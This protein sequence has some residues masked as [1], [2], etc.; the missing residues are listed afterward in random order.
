MPS[1]TDLYIQLF[2]KNHIQD[3]DVIEMSEHGRVGNVSTGTGFKNVYTLSPYTLELD[4]VGGENPIYLGSA[5]PG[6]STAS[7]VWQIKKITYDGNNNPTLIAVAGGAEYNQIWD[8]RAS[9]TYV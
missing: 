2:G 9:L 4:Y 6:S 5:V 8:D 1:L 7:P 3:G